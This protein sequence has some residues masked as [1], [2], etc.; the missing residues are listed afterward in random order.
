MYRSLMLSIRILLVIGL[1]YDHS[2]DQVQVP[3]QYMYSQ[4]QQCELCR[5][6]VLVAKMIKLFS[7][8]PNAAYVYCM[9]T[10]HQICYV[11]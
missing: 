6:F 2:V 9:H 7:Q 11:W 4:W 3:T 1:V 8:I 10:G 5:Y